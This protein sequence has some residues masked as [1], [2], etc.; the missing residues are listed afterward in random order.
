MSKVMQLTVTVRPYYQKNFADAYPKLARHL[1]HL[2]SNLVH[3]DPSLYELAG[4]LDHL[5]Y[6]FEGT[7][8]REVLLRHA[9]KLQGLRKNIDENIA[10]WKLAQA[11]K[12]LYGIED[13]FDEIE[14]ELG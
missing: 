12:L 11:D 4:Q 8:V 13:I 9:E 6:R 3:R 10:D 2:D 5:L 14:L 1:E 7:P